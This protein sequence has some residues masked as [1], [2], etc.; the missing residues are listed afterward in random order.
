MNKVVAIVGMCGSGKSVATKLFEDNGWKSVY[1]GGVTLQA[2]KERGLEIN[3][4][5]EKKIRETLREKY[6]KSAYAVKLLPIIQTL[7]VENNVVLDGLYSWSE[8]KYLCDNLGIALHVL[9]IISNRSVRYERLRNRCVRPLTGKE[10][11]QRD[12]AEI[13]NLEK[14]GPI[15]VADSYI[16]NNGMLEDFTES[17]LSFIHN[18]PPKND[19]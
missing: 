12:L 17:V 19:K 9:C 16:L 10:A 1:F 5:N 14:G 4:N 7:L 3:P 6:G 2:L 18:F 15:A 11:Y 13:E 8:Y